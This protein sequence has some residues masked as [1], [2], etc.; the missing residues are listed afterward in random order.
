MIW[1]LLVLINVVNLKVNYKV[2]FAKIIWKDV[3][4]KINHNVLNV[5]MVIKIKILME[6]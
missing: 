2:N 6:N 1:L 5:K 3:L 4:S